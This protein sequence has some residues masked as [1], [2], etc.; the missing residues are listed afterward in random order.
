MDARPARIART[1]AGALALLALA[2]AALADGVAPL[3]RTFR[4]GATF[5]FYGQINK[6]ILVYDDGR[7]TRGY[8]LIDNAV[9]NT[10]FGLSYTRKLGAWTFE[11]VNELK[12]AP[13]ST[14]NTNIVDRHPTF[15]AYERTKADI[16][17]MDFTLAH[18]RW[19]TFWAGQG[20]MASDGVLEIDL[21]GTDVVAYSGVGDI[22]SGQILRLSDPRLP[23]DESLTDL[24]IGDVFINLDAGREVR[25]RYDTRPIGG[26]TLA[27]SAGRNLLSGERETRNNNQ[28]DA[29]LVY[30][31][32]H[33]DFEV[34]GG[35]G[36]YWQEDGP[37]SGGGSISALHRPSGLSGTL[38][39]G[40]EDA[41]TGNRHYWYAKLGLTRRLL[42]SGP[43]SV[44]ADL[45]A[46]DDL[47]FDAEAGITSTTSRSTGLAL[48]HRL[49]RAGVDLWLTW[50]RYDYEDDAR[51]YET[52][53]A[54]FGGARFQF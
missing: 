43:T 39:V 32:T 23:F 30:A 29:S 52:S 50:R 11:N 21:S 48:V 45:F 14:T 35:L 16:R 7:D 36:T 17:K 18:P 37:A 33:G 19:G 31:G 13:F 47:F 27:V 24:E 41:P 49:E 2:G 40:T 3:E 46:G 28:V 44:S 15:V 26:F 22:A 53:E 8:P 38:S 34:A 1:L 20:S 6:G 54:V 9:S 10:R 51:S 25:L 42:A 5:R 4:N 12:H